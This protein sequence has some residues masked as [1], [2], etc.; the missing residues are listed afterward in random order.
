MEVF[1]AETADYVSVDSLEQLLLRL[2]VNRESVLVHDLLRLLMAEQQ[3]DLSS[4]E[5]KIILDHAGRLLTPDLRLEQFLDASGHEEMQEDDGR[6]IVFVLGGSCSS[7]EDL[8]FVNQVWKKNE[9]DSGSLA[10]TERSREL[11]LLTVRETHSSMKSQYSSF[12]FLADLKGLENAYAQLNSRIKHIKKRLKI[13]EYFERLRSAV[14]RNHNEQVCLSI[15]EV[16]A[17]VER[18]RGLVT[19][20]KTYYSRLSDIMQEVLFAH[21][22][23]TSTYETQSSRKSLMSYFNR[24]S[25]VSFAEVSMANT[26]TRS[27]S[28]KGQPQSLQSRVRHEH[29]QSALAAQR[30]WCQAVQRRHQQTDQHLGRKARL[31]HLLRLYRLLTQMPKSGTSSSRTSKSKAL[32]RNARLP[33]GCHW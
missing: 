8:N 31:P 27:S 11:L 12:E 22:L 25:L 24:E 9:N 28:R 32:R 6:R 3:I 19:E 23:E 4:L 15:D 33:I 1:F 10:S 26:G 18:V 30:R 14:F 16:N 20:F 7:E 29:P 5:S 13:F 21:Q 17:A 2:S